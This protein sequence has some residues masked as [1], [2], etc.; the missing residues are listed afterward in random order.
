M[1]LFPIFPKKTLSLT[2]LYFP[3]MNILFLLFWIWIVL[4][5]FVLLIQLEH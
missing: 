2:N 3:P 1:D 5:Y 4:L